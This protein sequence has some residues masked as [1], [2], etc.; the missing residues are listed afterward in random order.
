MYVAVDFSLCPI[1]RAPKSVRCKHTRCYA[2]CN[3]LLKPMM[4]ATEVAAGIHRVAFVVVLAGWLLVCLSLRCVA[5]RLI[6]VTIA[7]EKYKQLIYDVCRHLHFGRRENSFNFTTVVDAPGYFVGEELRVSVET[8]RCHVRYRIHRSWHC[9][10]D[11]PI[12][13]TYRTNIWQ[14]ELI[15]RTAKASEINS[16]HFFL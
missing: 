6:V 9:A 14:T 1:Y 3:P 5:L 13:Q 7:N 8:V 16:S 2:C 15:D 10:N 12:M 11:E 4:V